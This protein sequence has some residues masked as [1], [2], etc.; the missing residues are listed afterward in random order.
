[1]AD[2]RTLPS[3]RP[4]PTRD[5]VVEFL[6]AAGSRPV[7]ERVACFD[8]DGTLWCERPTYVQFDFCVDALRER[9]RADPAI[10]DTPEFAAV[11]N[12]DETAAR[13]LGLERI[14]LALVGL[15]DRMSPED[16]TARA[17]TFL[18]TANHQ[19]LQRPLLT[20]V[21]QPML[22]LIDELRLRQFTIC[23]V[24]GG[25]TEFVRAV[26]HDLYGVGP[27]AVVGTLIK[28]AFDRDADGHPRLRRTAQIQGDPNEGATKVTNIQT[29]L[30]RQPIFAAGNSG[31]D[32]EMLEW[33]TTGPGVTLAVLIDH[34][35]SQREF[36]YV[37]TAQTFVDPESVTDVGRRE[38]WTIVSMA[39][40]WHTI[41][42][43]PSDPP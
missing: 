30:G 22:E 16:F 35:D 41:F 29:Q 28:Y 42:P 27:E 6:D 20:T 21:Y 36:E 14:G 38:G 4:G 25:G 13:D 3:W 32:R 5:S 24:T 2:Q 39:N 8:N 7:G 43:T 40:D 33:A 34:D 11:L 9:H 26:S 15:F 37:S 12:R 1:M 18:A 23:I 19:T 31:G 10:A 17:R